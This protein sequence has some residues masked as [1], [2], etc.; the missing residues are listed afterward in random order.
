M[1]RVLLALI[2]IY[3][4]ALRPWWGRQCRYTPSC[5]EY[6]AEAIDRHGAARGAWMALRRVG[7]CHPWHEGGFD[8][9]P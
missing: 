2:E 5:S 9:V 1:K 4:M 7:R 6:A 3:R 8:P